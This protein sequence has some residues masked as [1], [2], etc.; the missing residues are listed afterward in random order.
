MFKGP[1]LSKCL[2]ASMSGGEL[3]FPYPMKATD[4]AYERSGETLGGS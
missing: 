3:V 2:S 1:G 4:V